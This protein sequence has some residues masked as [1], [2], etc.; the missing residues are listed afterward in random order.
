MTT[1]RALKLR[2]VIGLLALVGLL[3]AVHLSLNEL[4]LS[5]NTACLGGGSG[6]DTVNESRYVYAFG[7]PIALQGVIGYVLILTVTLGW[8]TRERIGPLPVRMVLLGLAEYGF[9]FSL[10]LTYLEAFKIHAF[11]TW[12]LV[13]A[14][15]MTAIF[16][17]CLAMW[18][19]EE[20]P[21]RVWGNQRSAP[22][23]SRNTRPQRK[24]AG[25]CPEPSRKVAERD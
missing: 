11:C 6:C 24:Q 16:G 22:G 8:M 3:I 20:A 1:E 15:L 19:A 12:C 25:A 13:S 14:G 21:L 2:M 17:L 7:P 4:R 9:V 23:V 10:V 18:I 5:S